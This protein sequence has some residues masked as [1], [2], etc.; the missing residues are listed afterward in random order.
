MI[1]KD[2]IATIAVPEPDLTPDALVAR[3]VAMRP[4][5]QEQQAAT[6][7]RGRIS[8]E[9]H[10][11]LCEGGFY[12]ILQ[13]RRFGGY[14]FDRE[15]FARMAIEFARGCT[16]TAWHIAF[17]SSHVTLLAQLFSEEA[18]IEA[19]GPEGDFI[20]PGRYPMGVATPA[21]DGGW[22]I[23][24]KWDYCSGAP[25]STHFLPSVII[26]DGKG[27]PRPGIIVIPRDQWTMLEDWGDV[28]GLRG[29]GSNSI[30]IENAHIPARALVMESMMDVDASPDALGYQLYGNPLYAGRIASMLLITLASIAVGTARAAV[31][32]FEHILRTRT[33]GFPP[34]IVPRYEAPDFHTTF[35]LADSIVNTAESSVLGLVRK[36][37]RLSSEAM[38]RDGAFS[39]EDDARLMAAFQQVI[40]KCFEA[41]QMVFFAGGSGAGRDGQPLQ[42]YYRDMSMLGTHAATQIESFSPLA[43]RIWTRDSRSMLG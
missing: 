6:E 13:P 20:A 25:Y 32:E 41:V 23:N 12:R 30:M 19:F 1:L 2:N 11:M 37:M 24:G 10:Q 40:R 7:G 4:H 3:A 27:P 16:S 22:L 5:L 26:K 21:E 43:T 28:L 18:Q 38:E 39:I 35:G 9:T 15:T 42:R 8:P 33:A 14:E 29:T 36:H 31:D 34:N 17:S